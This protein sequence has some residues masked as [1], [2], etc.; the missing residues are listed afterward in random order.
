[1]IALLKLLLLLSLFLLLPV[2][3]RVYHLN[4]S[5]RMN[6]LFMLLCLSSA[7][8]V[9]CEYELLKNISLERATQLLSWMSLIIVNISL[10]AYIVYLYVNNHAVV[11]NHYNKYFFFT[12]IT[13]PAIFLFFIYNTRPLWLY[14][15]VYTPELNVWTFVLQNNI[16]FYGFMAWLSLIFC[17]VIY[18][19]FTS[20][21]YTK[22]ALKK[23]WDKRFVIITFCGAILFLLSLHLSSTFEIRMIIYTTP[24]MLILLI[25]M[26]S[27]FSDFKLFETNQQNAIDNIIQSMSNILLLTDHNHQ[28]QSINKAGISL[29]NKNKKQIL[30]SKINDL[31]ISQA[32]NNSNNK[33]NHIENE[34]SHINQEVSIDTTKG[35]KY[36]SITINTIKADYRQHSRGLIYILTDITSIKKAQN[37]LIADNISLQKANKE[38]E[39]F[40]TITSEGLQSP[41]KKVQKNIHLLKRTHTEK[42]DKEG[43]TYIEYA[44]NSSIRMQKLLDDL[45]QYSKSS[46]EETLY[47]YVSPHLIIEQKLEDLRQF[48]Q[49]KKAIVQTNNLPLKIYGSPSMLGIV[50]YN[51]IH[52]ALKFNNTNKPIIV[53]NSIEE[54]DNYLFSVKD[55]GIGIEQK[56]QDK[57]FKLFHRLH[58]KEVYEGTGIG[59]SMCRNIIERHQGKIWFHSEKGKGTTF[60]FTLPKH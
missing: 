27:A 23:R 36:L 24:F 42:L 8:I 33:N 54:K 57:I 20:Y 37:Q 35:K 2:G 1:M 18:F 26:G 11:F 3:F 40:A 48:I 12:S 45:L 16:F 39:N 49:E 51:L 10:M 15:P 22:N 30:N 52:N 43:N 32:Y 5:Q 28:I 44:L 50:F 53:I 25:T 31:F 59:L 34:T 21:T 9:F 58:R 14:I 17:F 56:H 46:Q 47:I 60:Y 19:F 4:P 29:F 13:F 55:N 6:Q 41:L 38:L 7:Y